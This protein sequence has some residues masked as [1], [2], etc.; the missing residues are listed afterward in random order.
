MIFV[1]HKVMGRCFKERRPM[2]KSRKGWKIAVLIEAI[3]M[4]QI[5]NWKAAA[6]NREGDEGSYDPKI[7]LSAKEEKLAF[8]Y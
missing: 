1:S 6:R 3:D 8:P 2:E 5:W 4:V 7:G